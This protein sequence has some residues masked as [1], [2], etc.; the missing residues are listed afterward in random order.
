M[1]I[2]IN[3]SKTLTKQ[4]SYECKY[5]FDGGNCNSDQWW[6]NNKCRCDSKKRHV[7]NKDYVWK[8]ATCNCENGK[9]VASI[10]GD[11]AIICDKIIESYEEETN[12]NEKKQ[13]VKHKIPI[14]YLHFYCYLIKY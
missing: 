1:I 6:N 8:S 2:G 10:M 7:C 3:E 12:F 9:Y 4:I 13:P 5:K 11:S 14:F